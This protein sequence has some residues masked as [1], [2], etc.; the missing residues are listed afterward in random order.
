MK[1][2]VVMKNRLISFDKDK[3]KQLLHY[4]VAKCNG[5]NNVG[6]TVLYKMLY[7][8]DF[9]FYELN[10]KP[11]TGEQYYKL[12]Y[13]P[14]PSHFT[15]VVKELK[16]EKKIKGINSKYRGF[17][18]KRLISISEPNMNLLNGDEI[19]V[20]EKVIKR[21]SGMSGT[22]VSGYSHDDIPWKVTEKGKE[23]SYGLV[24]YRDKKYSVTA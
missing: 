7:F 12:N 9:D 22:M 1:R 13:G 17:P 6:R 19:Q 5:F 16:S 21:L 24:F 3:F 14:A 8:S 18:Q 2:D 10:Y 11:I 23:L 20:I 4:I 15:E